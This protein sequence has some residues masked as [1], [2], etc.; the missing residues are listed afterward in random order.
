MDFSDKIT[1][2][3]CTGYAYEL[4]GKGEDETV[5]Q[6]Y[7]RLQCEMSELFEEVKKIES[8]KDEKDINCLITTQQ[9]EQALKK[10]A[11]L[12]LEDTLGADVVTSITDPQGAQI[13]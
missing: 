4:V 5:L 10:L 3:L 12:K 8:L 7:Q 1:R 11:D 2:S 6:K 9:V 13:K